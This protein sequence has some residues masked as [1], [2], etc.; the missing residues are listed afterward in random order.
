MG[1]AAGA[2]ALKNPA[3]AAKYF[4]TAGQ[5]VTRPRESMI[6]GFR[7]GAANLKPGQIGFE[8]SASK[9]TGLYRDVFNQALSDGRLVSYEALNKAPTRGGGWLSMGAKKSAKDSLE[10]S[11]RLRARLQTAADDIAAGK[12]V[13]PKLMENLYAQLQAAGAS[14]N[15]AMK[16]GLTYYLPGERGMFVAPGLVGGVAGA[17]PSED[18]TGRKRGLGERLA[19]GAAGT[20]LG[21]A[22]APLM[23]GRGM[24]LEKG[25]QKLMLP[26]GVGAAAMPAVS[27][28][29]DVAGSGGRMIDT[30]FGQKE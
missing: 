5:L 28:G 12:R 22:T 17:L 7:E 10:I 25:F 23:I 9:R 26:M 20:Y 2:A 1:A 6:R 24:G 11:P 29:T 27:A 19:R 14:Q 30:A 15:L 21:V 8:Q 16:K 18:E 3:A 4:R 13:D